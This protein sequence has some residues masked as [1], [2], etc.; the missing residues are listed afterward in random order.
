V[1]YILRV[2]IAGYEWMTAS[3]SSEKIETAKKRMKNATIGIFIFTMI[4]FIAYFFISNLA[5][6]AGYNISIGV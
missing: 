4:Y 6:I 1:H 5:R 3:G 2:I